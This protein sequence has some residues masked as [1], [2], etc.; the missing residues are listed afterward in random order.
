MEE[1]STLQKMCE[2]NRRLYELI[3][4]AKR[5]NIGLWVDIGNL[6]TDG[7][8]EITTCIS[9]YDNGKPSE[10]IGTYMFFEPFVD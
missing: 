5:N 4:E 7:N 3:T 9:E 8:L 6:Q 2:Y 10:F 1:K